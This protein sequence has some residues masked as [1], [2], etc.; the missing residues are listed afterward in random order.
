MAQN[1]RK[2]YKVS[3]GALVTVFRR[4]TFLVAA[5]SAEAA[6]EKGENMFRKVGCDA[7][8]DLDSVEVDDIEEV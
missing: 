3:C 2:K 5:D 1:A 8:W 7:G 4:R 6:R